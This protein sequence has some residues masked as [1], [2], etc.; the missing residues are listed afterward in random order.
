MPSMRDTSIMLKLIMVLLYMMTEWL[1]WMKPMP[2]AQPRAAQ[3][4]RAFASTEQ[5][6]RSKL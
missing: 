1:D 5:P 2:G 4:C 6:I 3:G